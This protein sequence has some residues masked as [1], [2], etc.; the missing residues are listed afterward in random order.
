MP[1]VMHVEQIPHLNHSL[2]KASGSQERDLIV[3]QKK[4]ERVALIRV[5]PAV[6]M[7]EQ[8]LSTLK[9][10]VWPVFIA[11]FGSQNQKTWSK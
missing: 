6:I 4:G 5:G 11:R 7:T 9:N 1:P 8:P 10:K 2:Y 3:W